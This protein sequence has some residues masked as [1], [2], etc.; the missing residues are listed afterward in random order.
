MFF[1]FDTL[2][3]ETQGDAFASGKRKFYD[4]K[5]KNVTTALVDGKPSVFAEVTGDKVYSCKIIFDEQGG[6]Y[7]YSC[8][9]DG[10]HLEGGPCKHLVATALAFEEKNPQTRY[11]G[12][13]KKKTDGG[14]LNLISQYAKKKRRNF[15]TADTLKTEVIPYLELSEGVSL[16]FTIGNQKHYI[17]K[18]VS[19]FVSCFSAGGYRRY[20]AHLDLY[21]LPQNFT[22]SSLKLIKFICDCYREKVSVNSAYIR[23]KDELRL[24]YS[25]VDEFFALYEGT[26]VHLGKTDLVL[27]E[28]FNSSFP[29]K[30]LVEKVNDGFE[31][32]LSESEYKFIDGR[33]YTYVLLGNRI[34]RITKT[35]DEGIREFFDALVI[36]K[37]LFV[38]SSDMSPFYNSV[39]TALNKFLEV[40]SGETDISVYEASPLVCK[41]FISGVGEEV[42]L[43][44]K[45]NYDD[46]EFDLLSD[47]TFGD[48]VR[49]WETENALR[50]ILSKYFRHYPALYIDDEEEIFNFLSEGVKELFAY[51]EVFI[52]ESMKKLKIRPTPRIH[53]GVRLASDLLSLETSA[54]GYTKEEIAQI[55]QAYREKKR[56]IRLGGGFVGLDDPSFDALADILEVAKV[57]D[58]TFTLPRY[59]APFVGSELKRGYFALD[60]D[61]AFKSLIKSLDGAEN[62]DIEVPESLRLTMRNYQKTGF[63]W[64]KT[65]RESGFGGI[66][67]DDMGLGKSLQ[68]IAM[69]LEKKCSALI[70]CPT[71]LMYNWLN[72]FEK[73]APSLS[74]LLVTGS[75]EERKELI[76]KANEYD[77]VITSYDLIRRDKALYEPFEFDYAIADEAQFI[78]NPETKNAIAVKGIRAKHRFALTGTPV[79]NHLGELWSIFDFIMPSYL[80]D[81]ASFRDKYEID[82]V[83]GDGE[84]TEKL[85]R[86]VKPFI[87]RRLKSEVLKELPPKTESVISSPM[88]EEQR[89]LYDADM[90]LI[91]ES[92]KKTPDMSKVVV[93]GM[94]TRLRQICCDP[95][96]IYSGYDGGSAKT[97]ACMQLI[98]SAVDGGHKILLFSQFTTMLDLIAK[99]LMERG[100]S[101]YI[102]KGDT[103]KQ[104]RLRLV[105][106]FNEN[107][108]KV[109]LISLKA[110]GTGINLTGADVVIHYDPWW[111]ES[112]MNQATDRAYRMG[113]NKSVQVYKLICADSIEEKIMKLQEKKSALSSQ[114]VGKGNGIREIIELFSQ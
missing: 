75:Q 92:M 11:A 45:S 112:V 26:L 3:N 110:G 1:D 35:L 90:S 102:L 14:A 36:K 25:D 34:Y 101:H 81:Y 43:E 24:L 97:E 98:E 95:A 55:L 17:L 28:P 107:E 70:V 84:A 61:S 106:K 21:H 68:I 38:A 46:N 73:F 32:S 59:Y 13:V 51:A 63:R 2:Y 22:D 19:D 76:A 53:V 77:A 62:A 64:L 5:V 85:Q 78:K 114:V 27:V 108:V 42:H 37:K 44:V 8:S 7:D 57:T 56:Y 67:A 105:S 111:N 86:L 113:Q 80:G 65:L 79:E 58:G 93:L 4:D 54:E 9:C 69:L 6:L 41:I 40:D 103:P 89:K 16:R 10:F 87:L 52:T 91:R 50:G 88:T 23:Y 74:I 72:E 48:F 30:L 39:I 29:V 96:L 99:G 83:R 20:G 47:A 33:D 66:L 82:V 18:D 12:V 109:F 94:L 49:D 31:V 100:I 60:R 15:I 71:T 104:E